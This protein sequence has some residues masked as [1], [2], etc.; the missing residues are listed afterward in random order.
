MKEQ[1]F[2]DYAKVQLNEGN[3]EKI[4]LPEEYTQLEYIESTGT[5]YIDTKVT[6]DKVYGYEIEY[7]S[8]GIIKSSPS[9]NLD[10]I[11]GVNGA[12]DD[13]KLW[14]G[15]AQEDSIRNSIYFQSNTKQTDYVSYDE[16]YKKHRLKILNYNVYYDNERIAE[17]KKPDSLIIKGR[18]IY[19]FSV[20]YGN[21]G[22]SF[23]SHT[24]L[25]N[26]KLYDINNKLICNLIPCK[27]ADGVL[28]LY[29]L[30][31]GAFLINSG[32]RD[33]VAGDEI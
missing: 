26:L 23:Y 31:T 28:G 8:R 12:G 20:N 32:T 13:L 22:S 25:Y 17:F 18:S 15:Y 3:I 14:A 11:F 21:V 16:Y 1:G 10:G 27:N 4:N 29:D 5:Q 24:R 19:I 2:E 9:Y 30:V 7:E 33:F 6:H